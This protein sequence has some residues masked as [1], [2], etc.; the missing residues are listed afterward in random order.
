MFLQSQ[1]C[2]FIPMHHICILYLSIKLFSSI[3]SFNTSSDIKGVK[4]NFKNLKWSTE[5]NNF[6]SFF[7]DLL[8]INLS[9]GKNS[10]FLV[11]KI[12]CTPSKPCMNCVT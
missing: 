9:T 11:E 3:R 8:S 2:V 7:V 12:C 5:K 4:N 1:V 10:S 6:L